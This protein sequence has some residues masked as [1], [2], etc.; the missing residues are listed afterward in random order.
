M[1]LICLIKGHIPRKIKT[2]KV[3][4]INS[5]KQWFYGDKWECKRCKERTDFRFMPRWHKVKKAT[6][7]TK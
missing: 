5:I 2:I 6:V 4:D 1:N 3:K 7:I